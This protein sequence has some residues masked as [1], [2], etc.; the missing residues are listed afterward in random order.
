MGLALLASLRLA[1]AGDLLIVEVQIAGEKNSNDLVKIHNPLDY[2]L[3]IGG[4][5]LKKRS[6]TGKESSIRAFPKGTKIPA[7]GHLLW[8]NSKDDFHLIIGADLWSKASLSQNNSI[9]ILNPDGVIIDALAWGK[10]KDPFVLGEPFPENPV[11]N[12]QLKRRMINGTYQNT[13][14][15]H[16]DFYLQKE[17]N[18]EIQP[19]PLIYPEGIVLNEILAKTP[20]GVKDEEGE[21][22]EIFNQNSFKVDL[23]NW[24]IEDTS[25][26][27]RT[28]TFPKGTEIVAQGFLVFKRPT[29]KITLNNT[30]EGINLIAPDGRIVDTV[31]YEKALPGQSYNRT[32]SGWVWSTSLTPGQKNIIMAPKTKK[33]DFKRIDINKA[34]T[35]ELQRITG[36]GPVL[37]KRIIDA[38]PFRS[39]DELTKVKGIGPRTL[40]EI[41]EQGLAWVDPGLKIEETG[42]PKI[43][44]E[45]IPKPLESSD[46]AL[47]RDPS[48]SLFLLTGLIIIFSA[49]IILYKWRSR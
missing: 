9:A 1:L 22:I 29:T 11:A 46:F 17:P 41:K 36:I 7:K 3:D 40:N 37:A 42:S 14:Q 47:E 13:A 21:Y 18:L 28:Y 48:K 8:A 19:Q 31:N 38:R 12:Q 4:Y 27:K 44:L 20:L 25:G 45:K 32:P 24:K 26:R 6:S 34:S 35:K 16:K 30:F 49:G 23:S 39:L 5:R 43:N 10:G 15:N 2:D 33:A